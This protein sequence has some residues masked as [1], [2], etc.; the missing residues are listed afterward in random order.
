MSPAALADAVLLLHALIVAFIVLG[1]PLTWIGA[2]RGWAFVR[3][4]WFRLTHLGLIGFVVGQTWLNQLCPLTI[5]EHQLRVAAGQGGYQ[6][7]F[8]E[9]W[10]SDLIF[11]DLS[12]SVLAFV[13]TGFGLLVCL[14]LWWVP[15][16][17][18]HAAARE[19]PAARK[20]EAA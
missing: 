19:A 11:V 5:W 18:A 4:A 6:R 7:S 1:L 14:T 13:Y 12:L 16:G 15:I 3:R 9:H 17:S 2:W 10:L 20:P 8:I